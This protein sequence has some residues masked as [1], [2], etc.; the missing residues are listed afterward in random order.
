MYGDDWKQGGKDH[1]NRVNKIADISAEKI[2][3]LQ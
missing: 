2:C 1:L 3:L